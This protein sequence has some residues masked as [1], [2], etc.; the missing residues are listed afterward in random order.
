[1]SEKMLDYL[2]TLY[3]MKYLA[4]WLNDVINYMINLKFPHILYYPV[5][6]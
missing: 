4:L 2:K 6:L 5:K 3:F 1:M